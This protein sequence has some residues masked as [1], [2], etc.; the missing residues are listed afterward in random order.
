MDCFVNHEAIKK[1]PRTDEK[2]GTQYASLIPLIWP[3]SHLSISLR[4]IRTVTKLYSSHVLPPP[5]PSSFPFQFLDLIDEF[6]PY[7]G[8]CGRCS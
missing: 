1:K 3:D 2:L 6:S 4:Y 8:A 5:Q 7:V